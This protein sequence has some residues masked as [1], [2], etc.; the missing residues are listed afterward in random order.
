VK[1]CRIFPM[2][3]LNLARTSY[4]RW[5]DNDVC[6]VLDQPTLLDVDSAGWLKQHPTGRHV[7]TLDNFSSFLLVNIIT[8]V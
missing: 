5:N 7:A 8:I 2:N 3:I 6:F 4:I 1:D